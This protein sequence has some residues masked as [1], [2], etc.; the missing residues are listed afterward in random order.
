MA[1]LDQSTK[2]DGPKSRSIMPK[3]F[4]YPASSASLR[5]APTPS[6]PPPPIRYLTAESVR[7]GTQVRACEGVF[8]PQVDLAVVEGITIDV[9]A[10][11][12]ITLPPRWLAKHGRGDRLQPRESAA[13][14]DMAAS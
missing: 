1:G 11:L 12:P 4:V 7:K 8:D 13:R 5:I 2:F 3:T 6:R 14:I 9:G 10:A